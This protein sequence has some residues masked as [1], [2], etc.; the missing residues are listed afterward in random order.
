[1][2]HS[3]SGSD[4][5]RRFESISRCNRFRKLPNVDGKVPFIS[6]PLKS[7]RDRLDKD[8]IDVGIEPDKLDDPIEI[9]I[10]DPLT[11]HETLSQ[12]DTKDEQILPSRGV[13]FEQDHDS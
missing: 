13:L 3:D 4:P 7:S 1:M 6:L 9:A 8:P 2:L 11:L 10:I 5:S 12:C